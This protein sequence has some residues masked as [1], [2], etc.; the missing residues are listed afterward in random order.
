MPRRAKGPRLYL[1]PEREGRERVWS[2]RD[3]QRKHSTGCGEAQAAEA[4]Q[5]LARYIAEKHD[6]AARRDRAPGKVY[7]SDVISTYSDDVVA[8]HSRPNESA[9]RLARILDY[10]GTKTLGELSAKECRAYVKKRGSKTGARRDLEDLRSAIRHAWKEGM[11]DTLVPVTLPDKPEARERW[12]SR[13]EAARLLWAAW[14]LKAQGRRTSQHIARFILVALYTGTRAGAVCGAAIRPTVG[15]GGGF[16]DLDRGLF[17]RKAPGAKETKKRAPP[18]AL[19]DRL[20]AHLRRWEAKG[21]SKRF[22]VEWRGE[23]VKRVSKGFR[24]V[25]AEAGLGDDVVPHT[26]RH[27]ASTWLSMSGTELGEAADYV[28]M[29]A[30][31]YV[32]VYRHHAPGYQERA[33]NNISRRQEGDRNEAKPRERDANEGR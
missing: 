16:I 7:V 32:R 23:A 27:T 12:L 11:V 15:H 6:P 4:E 18:V 21:I 29:S 24:G 13:P 22:V 8:N 31:T 19:P 10:F 26:L 3:G 9:A 25:R 1:E 20:I 17:Y 28:G 30:E 14:T 2:I 5:A 33:R